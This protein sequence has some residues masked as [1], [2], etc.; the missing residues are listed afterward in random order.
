MPPS[1]G[2]SV[3][4]GSGQ[5]KSSGTPGREDPQD[6][7]RRERLS[8]LEQVSSALDGPMILLSAAWIALLIAELVV[9][10]PRSLEVAVWAI[11]GVFII[12]FLL[13]FTIAPLKLRYLR[14]QWLTVL[15]LILPAFR[16]FRLAAGLRFLATLRFVR[17]VGL[18][19]MITSINRGLSSLRLTAARRGV[20]YVFAASALVLV[21]GGAGMAYFEA[22][23][24]LSIAGAT[25]GTASP[26]HDY[27]DALWWTAHTMTTGAPREAATSEGKLLGWLLSLYGLVIFGYLTATLASHFVGRDRAA[28]LEARSGAA[29]EEAHTPPPDA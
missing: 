21:V 28:P 20:P 13:E 2:P 24:S 19:Q 11:W 29:G 12:D 17:T 3:R 23:G 7:L 27:G 25:R 9:G 14:T 1:Q 5:S 22:S 18:L 8:L 4:G 6:S 15:S 26:L 10:L 16:I